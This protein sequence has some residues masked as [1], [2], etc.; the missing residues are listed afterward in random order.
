MPDAFPP[1]P[2]NATATSHASERRA[3]GTGTRRERGGQCPGNWSRSGSLLGSLVQDLSLV[4]RLSDFNYFWAR[5]CLTKPKAV[6]EDRQTEI[7]CVMTDELL[8][9][10]AF[11]IKKRFW[12]T[13]SSEGCGER[14]RSPDC[15]S[16][17]T[18]GAMEIQQGG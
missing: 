7:S 13:Q 16:F 1:Q 8:S 6:Q 5:F 4:Q 17:G 2:A 9:A 11:C 12:S 14:W 15:I 3:A 18:G 10:A